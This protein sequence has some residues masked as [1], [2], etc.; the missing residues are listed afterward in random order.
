MLNT[1]FSKVTVKSSS[2]ASSEISANYRIQDSFWKRGQS[3]TTRTQ[4]LRRQCLFNFGQMVVSVYWMHWNA[5]NIFTGGACSGAAARMR[6]PRPRARSMKFRG[7]WKI[8]GS[9]A[10]GSGGLTLRER[11]K[12][13]RS[14]ASGVQKQQES[15]SSVLHRDG[16]IAGY[17]VSWLLPW[18]SIFV[19]ICLGETIFD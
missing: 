10:S 18:S 2:S 13:E 11:M 5:A 8:N 14:L 17:H 19:A 4:I 1:S 15:R 12:Y 6:F 16:F 9:F 7:G 3:E